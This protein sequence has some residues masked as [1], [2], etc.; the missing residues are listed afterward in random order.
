MWTFFFDFFIIFNWLYNWFIRHSYKFEIKIPVTLRFL[1]KKF[2]LIIIN[3]MICRKGKTVA[4]LKGLCGAFEL[5]LIQQE[6]KKEDFQHHLRAWMLSAAAPYILRSN[7][8]C[9]SQQIANCRGVQNL[10]GAFYVTTRHS[11]LNVLRFLLH[12]WH[13]L[14]STRPYC[15]ILLLNCDDG[16]L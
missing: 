6:K 2:Y 15:F 14:Y 7:D 5:E 13:V 11:S 1:N 9:L 3:E 8:F 10:S 4:C 16:A 12:S